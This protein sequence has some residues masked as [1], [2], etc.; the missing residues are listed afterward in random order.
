MS[1]DRV[2]LDTNVIVYAYDKHDPE[3][4]EKARA[5]VK[6]GVAEGN[7]VLS[8]QVLGEFF[9]VVTRQVPEPLSPEETAEIIELLSVMPVTEIDLPLVKRAM[10][11]CK[12]YGIS[13]WDS[14]IV[15][16]AERAKCRKILSEDFNHG[17]EYNGIVVENPFRR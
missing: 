3:K 17:Q 7:A 2:F 1:D 13:Y 6:S 5:L 15:A 10:G 16:A 12:E 4:M 9:V 14:L 8:T 11:T